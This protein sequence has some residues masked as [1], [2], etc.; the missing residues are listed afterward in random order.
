MSLGVVLHAA[1][2]FVP[3]P[4]GQRAG[5][6][7]NVHV[8]G[9]IHGFRMPLFFLV[10]GYFTTMI[11]RRNGARA[12][13]HKRARKIALP[14]ALA[15]VTILPAVYLTHAAARE[16][17]DIEHPGF[18]FGFSHLWFLWFLIWMIPGYVVVAEAGRWFLARTGLSDLF[19]RLVPLG[20]VGLLLAP[21]VAAMRM[22]DPVFGADYSDGLIPNDGVL[23]YYA[24]FFAFG[25]MAYGRTTPGG[26]ALID[27][28]GRF[29]ALHL[30][31]ATFVFYPA[32]HALMNDNWNV[33]AVLQIA[34]AWSFVFA[35]LGLFRQ[36]FAD[37]SPGMRWLADSSYW[38]YLAHLPLIIILQ[39]LAT[40]IGLPPIAATPL[41]VVVATPLLLWSYQTMVRSTWIGVLLN[42]RRT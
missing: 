38:I 3:Y 32:G 10:S 11:W 27:A 33:S 7:L 21:I 35:M 36:F 26:T 15:V 39:G 6:T 16:L 29:W 25:A 1:I 24:C 20:L 34:F 2:A 40:W 5:V 22:T 37:D 14:L 28:V 31:V 12:L 19:E 4:E 42:G 9:F 8:F 30:F 41:V 18:R 13:V 23:F 17:M